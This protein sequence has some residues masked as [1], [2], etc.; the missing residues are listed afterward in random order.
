MKDANDALES[1]LLPWMGQIYPFEWS[2]WYDG[3]LKWEWIIYRSVL[4]VGTVSELI[5]D[6]TQGDEGTPKDRLYMRKMILIS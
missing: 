4:W 3:G 6:L 2:F 1:L 5:F